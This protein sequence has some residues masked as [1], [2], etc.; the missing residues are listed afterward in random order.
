MRLNSSPWIQGTVNSHSWT[1]TAGSTTPAGTQAQA[2]APQYSPLPTPV[3]GIKA[4]S[5]AAGSSVQSGNLTLR[6][7]YTADTYYS[8]TGNRTLIVRDENTG[9]VVYKVDIK[10][11][12]PQDSKQEVIL[13]T[14]VSMQSGH[15][16]SVTANRHF[17]R[18]LA[19][20]WSVNAIM[21]KNWSFSVN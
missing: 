5:P 16:Y 1:F 15:K 11:G 6:I 20:P 17:A 4:V 18:L 21:D 8:W 13:N 9:S 3:Q 12:D 2:Q 14:G 19:Y 7:K 10:P